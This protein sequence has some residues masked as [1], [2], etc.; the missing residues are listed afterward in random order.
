MTAPRIETLSEK[1]MIG[2]SLPMTLGN[3]QTFKLWSS[4]M[5]RRKGIK[6]AIGTDFYSIQVYD[7]LYSFETFNP[8]IS[9][10]KWATIEVTGFENVPENM[11]TLT[12]KE[13]LYAVFI[14]KG[15]VQDF[16]R[17]MGFIF[18]KWL[19][20]S[21]YQLDNRPHFEVLGKKYKNNNPSSEEEVWIPICPRD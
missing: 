17:T 9:F 12:I 13:G 6:N 3:D 2:Q 14:H 4:F 8:K 19:P 11:A 21:P 20:N 15:T 16:P 10:E 5:P 1:K 7:K 18:G